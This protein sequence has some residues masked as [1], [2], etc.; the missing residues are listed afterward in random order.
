MNTKIKTVV[1]G[2]WPL[3][4]SLFLL[5]AFAPGVEA[6]TYLSIATGGEAGVYYPLGSALAEMLTNRLPDAEVTAR[7]SDASAANVNMI[8]GREAELAFV[9][10]DVALRAVNG[11]KPFKAPVRNLS[12]IASLYPEHVQC[13]TVRSNGVKTL[14]DLRGKRVSVGSINSGT[15]DSVNAVL[16][17]AG[18]KYKDI[19]ADFLDFANTSLR[20]QDG[21]LDAGFILAGYP[22]AAVADL[23]AKKDLDIVAFEEELL[24]KLSAAYP[25]F[26]K[27]VI[28][29]RTYDG[30]DHDTQTI[31]VMA[32]LVCDSGMPDDLVYDITKA[33]F[34]N[35]PELAMAHPRAETISLDKALSA[36]VINVHPGAAKYYTEKGL[37]IPAF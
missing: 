16:S 27:D 23:A 33:I 37:K 1:S 20:I 30:I 19:N 11:E 9:Q 31:A 25:F 8:A 7:T 21:Q 36:A 4:C 32:V 14:S 10:N 5:L 3:I 12:M 15:I 28:P 6:K 13:V 34:D 17:V 29:A 18:I 2:Q 24:D 26:I 35:L 22:T